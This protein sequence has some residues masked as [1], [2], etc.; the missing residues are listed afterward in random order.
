MVRSIAH[1]KHTLWRVQVD[2]SWLAFEQQ[3]WQFKQETW[4]K[5]N[6]IFLC[7]CVCLFSNGNSD[8]QKRQRRYRLVIVTLPCQL[9]SPYKI[10]RNRR[11]FQCQL[12]PGEPVIWAKSSTDGFGDNADRAA[13]ESTIN[14]DNALPTEERDHAQFADIRSIFSFL[15]TI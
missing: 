11:I 15:R 12:I 13:L 1:C 3:S 7:V 4:T 6:L 2:W 14:R 10:T 8:Y 9:T 5:K